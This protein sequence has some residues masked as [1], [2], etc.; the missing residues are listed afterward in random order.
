VLTNILSDPSV[1]DDKEL[2]G[3]LSQ[4]EESDPLPSINEM[5]FVWGP[6]SSAFQSVV[7]GSDTPENALKAA[8]EA[9]LKAIKEGQ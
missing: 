5:N 1:K 2:A 7:R 9:I 6:A 3:W 4:L 8:Q